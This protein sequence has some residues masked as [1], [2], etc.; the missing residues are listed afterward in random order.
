M[1]VRR[2]SESS[3]QFPARVRQLAD[4]RGYNVRTI[5]AGCRY[6]L[7]CTCRFA[8][9]VVNTASLLAMTASWIKMAKPAPFSLCKAQSLNLFCGPEPLQTE[10]IWFEKH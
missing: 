6:R 5:C 4:V 7:A 9:A 10:T 2:L 8:T 1:P 3:K